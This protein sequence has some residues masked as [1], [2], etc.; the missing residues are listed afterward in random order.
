MRKL[1]NF[2][3]N[4]RPATVYPLLAHLCPLRADI[5]QSGI[6]IVII[7][8]LLGDLYF[9]IHETTIVDGERRAFDSCT[10]TESEIHRIV[11]K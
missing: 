10:Y 3:A 5:A 11:H 8:E 7:R 2:Y 6:D 1:C 4:V 9:G